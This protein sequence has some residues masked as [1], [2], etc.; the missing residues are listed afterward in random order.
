MPD[1]FFSE[2]IASIAQR[3]PAL[4]PRHAQMRA[5]GQR[6]DITDLCSALLSRRGEASG[7][8]LA[9]EVRVKLQPSK[10][11]PSHSTQTFERA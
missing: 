8:G 7:D 10:A 2:L 11:L 5:I 6:A 9:A 3:G 4:F 1:S